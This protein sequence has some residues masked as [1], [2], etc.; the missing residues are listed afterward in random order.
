MRVQQPIAAHNFVNFGRRWRSLTC[1]KRRFIKVR[2]Q[3]KDKKQT[4]DKK[5]CRV[6]KFGGSSSEYGTHSYLRY[7]TST[8]LF[9]EKL[10]FVLAQFENSVNMG[11]SSDSTNSSNNA[12]TKA[13]VIA[14][15]S[16]FSL[17]S[18]LIVTGNLL[19]IVLFAANKKIRKKC[20]FLVV[21]MACA[22]LLIGAFS[23]PVQIITP[24]LREVTTSLAV[25]TFFSVATVV[26]LQATITFA[27]LIS[28]ERLCATCWPLKY[29]T[30]SR[31]AYVVLIIL[32]W[33]L[34][35]LSSAI[36]S[37]LRV[38]VSEVAYY[39][40]WVTYIFT[41]TF[42]ICACT[43]GIWRI[44]ENRRKSLSSQ[45]NRALQNRH[46]TKTL[47]LI[48]VLAFIS[49]IPI[50]IINTLE[51]TNV[52]VNKKLYYLAVLLNV[53]NCCANPVVY[54]LRIPEFRKALGS[55]KMNVNG[56][57]S[58]RAFV[59]TPVTQLKSTATDLEEL[60][61]KQLGRETAV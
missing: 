21:N 39:S 10:T 60:D 4:K 48:S 47:V 26:C 40:F 54:A 9:F 34:V 59:L 56:G 14:W 22:D 16:A 55:P 53:S 45:Q 8:P 30:L 20:F 42:I 13:E 23:L 25:A 43:F 17:M 32:T 46:L 52:S 12:F 15:C 31:R 36:L 33:T 44:F 58:N 61:T 19:T 29:R 3:N 41:L 28:L 35:L 51:A 1:K 5:D 6:V 50:I 2:L 57:G 11:S 37:V 18:V 49:W 24:L 7:L 38:F 27:A